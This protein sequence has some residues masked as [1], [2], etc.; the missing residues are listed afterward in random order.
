MCTRAGVECLLSVGGTG[1]LKCCE[2]GWRNGE[3]GQ[4]SGE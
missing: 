2:C 4:K 3:G 1:L